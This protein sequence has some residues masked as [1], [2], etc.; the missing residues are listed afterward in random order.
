[1]PPVTTSLEF[2]ANSPVYETDKP[3]IVFPLAGEVVTDEDSKRL[4][5]IQFQ[6]HPLTI[7]DAREG[8]PFTLETSGFQIFPHET[9]SIHFSDLNSVRR[10]QNE[11]DAFLAELLKPEFV[12]SYD[13]K[14]CLRKLCDICLQALTSSRYVK[15]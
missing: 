10:Y 7:E 5:N 6:S 8:G 13:C 11:M 1:M 3:Y 15:M 14:V 4:S 2:L 9:Q 12:M